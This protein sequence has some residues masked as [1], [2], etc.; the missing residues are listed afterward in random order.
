MSRLSS[1]LLLS[2][3]TLFSLNSFTLLFLFRLL[4]KRQLIFFII[5]SIF[6]IICI[7][8]IIMFICIVFNSKTKK[9]PVSSRPALQFQNLKLIFLPLNLGNSL[10]SVSRIS[11]TS[12]GSS[13]ARSLALSILID[14]RALFLFS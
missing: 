13:T 9:T 1:F 11:L 3:R 2:L 4:L 7:I 12:I 10:L 14:L 8:I 6:S 5:E